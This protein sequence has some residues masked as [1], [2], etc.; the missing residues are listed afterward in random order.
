MKKVKKILLTIT[1]FMICAP[2]FVFADT[3]NY[4]VN[5]LAI[6]QTST[7]KTPSVNIN[8]FSIIII[9]MIVLIIFLIG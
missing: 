1:F 3:N 5:E 8:N 4:L 2:S 6:I 9:F 7:M